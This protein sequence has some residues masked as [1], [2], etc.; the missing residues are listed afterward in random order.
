VEPSEP[1][2]GELV[3]RDGGIHP[4]WETYLYADGRLLSLDQFAI[5]DGWVEQ[6]LTPEGVELLRSAPSLSTNW[7]PANAWEDA[8]PEPYVPS[9]Y[10]VCTS[11][12]TIRLLP[13]D[14][15]HLLADASGEQSIRR[16]EVDFLESGRGS[17][18]PEVR[19]DEARALEALLLR[20]GFESLAT[21]GEVIYTSRDEDAS[22]SL[23]SLLPDG[24][25]SQCCP[26]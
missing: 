8:E 23:I 13:K 18:C 21:R 4:W 22:M 14:A 11:A 5:E 25:F 24:T 15:Q 16:G 17:T 6:R 20:D 10:L 26:G 3:K 7:L 2:R 12:A 1:L 9:R 19:L